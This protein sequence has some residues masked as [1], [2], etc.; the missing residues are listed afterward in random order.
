MIL[1]A[2]LLYLAILL[3]GVFLWGMASCGND[4]RRV[5]AF[6]FVAFVSAALGFLS[7]AGENGAGSPLFAI[8]SI[9]LGAAMALSGLGMAQME[10]EMDAEREDAWKN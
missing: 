6:L 5:I 7:I 2:F 8:I 10:P 4:F 3:F 1:S 9:C